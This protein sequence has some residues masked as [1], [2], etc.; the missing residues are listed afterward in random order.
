MPIRGLRDT[1]PLHW[2]GSLADPFQNV[3]GQ[4][5]QPEDE[6]APDCDLAVDGEVGC[7]RHLVDASLCGVMCD[8]APGGGCSR[9]ARPA[10]RAPS[11]TPSAT[12]WRPSCWPCRTRRRRRAA[13]TTALTEL[14]LDNLPAR[15]GFSDFFTDLDGLGVGSPS[16][17]IGQAVGFAP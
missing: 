14:A 8:P 5:P 13:T 16:N 3:E 7:T 10:C 6:G 4:L 9:R 11:A 17:D 2:M 12:T 1:L 15:E